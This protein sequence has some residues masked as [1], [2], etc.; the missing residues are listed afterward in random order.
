MDHLNFKTF[1]HIDL[2]LE[3]SPSPWLQILDTLFPSLRSVAPVITCHEILIDEIA[4]L[5][6]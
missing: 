4:K 3:S 1:R 2:F 5:T 6:M